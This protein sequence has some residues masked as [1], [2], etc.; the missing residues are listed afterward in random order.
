MPNT[1]RR[2]ITF[3]IVN[4]SILVAVGLF[5]IYYAITSPG[6]GVAECTIHRTLNLYCPV[7]G[8]TRSLYSVLRFDIISAIRFHAFVPFAIGIF[9]YC[10]IRAFMAIVKKQERVIYLHKWSGFVFLGI[11]LGYFIL[12]N[13][14]LV[15]FRIDLT[16]DFIY[17]VPFWFDGQWF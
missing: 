3:A 4:G 13:V 1:R 5:F 2:I 17:N 12:R 10:D 7:C 14:L 11:F 15:A 6:N 8:G 9:I 16:G